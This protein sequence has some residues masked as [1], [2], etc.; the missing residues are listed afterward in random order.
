[1]A[2]SEDYAFHKGSV[3]NLGGLVESRN[4]SSS[5]SDDEDAEEEDDESQ[6]KEVQLGIEGSMEDDEASPS[7]ARICSSQLLHFDLQGN[8]L[9]F[10]GWLATSKFK[11]QQ[12]QRFLTLMKEPG[13]SGSPWTLKESNVACLKSA[14]YREFYAEE[15]KIVDD[16]VASAKQSS[17][18]L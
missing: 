2:G 15:Q 7:P 11:N 3:G 4:P 14:D 8:P 10:N 17:R 5:D 9:W 12:Y 13:G 16:L 1:M 18:G 6:E